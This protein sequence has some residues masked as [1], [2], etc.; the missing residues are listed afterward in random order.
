[1]R[2]FFRDS[3]LWNEEN[4]AEM[5]LYGGTKARNET[6]KLFAQVAATPGRWLGKAGHHLYTAQSLFPQSNTGKR[7]SGSAWRR[8]RKW[9]RCPIRR[10]ALLT[11]K[12]HRDVS[13]GPSG[14]GVHAQFRPLLGSTCSNNMAVD[15]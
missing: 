14:H 5:S 4:G 13:R 15:K 6:R 12:T 1:M 10:R 9:H 2:D 3:A 7:R 8:N 11:I